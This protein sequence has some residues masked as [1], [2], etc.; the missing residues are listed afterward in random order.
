MDT[1]SSPRHRL[2]G[3]AFLLALGVGLVM[4]VPV[5]ADYLGPDRTVTTWEWRRLLCHYEAVY[6]PPGAGWY[7]CTLDLYNTPASSCPS[8]G[9]VVGY[10]TPSACSWP[11]AFCQTPGCNMSLSTSVEGCSEGQTGCTAVSQT[12][13]LPEATVSGWVSCGVPG[14]GGWCLADADLS[15]T[16]SEPLAGYSILTLEGTRNVIPGGGGETFACLGALFLGRH[17]PDG[18]DQRRAGYPPA[19]DLW[20]DLRRHRRQRLVPL[21][22]RLQRQRQRS[23]PRVRALELRALT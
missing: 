8:T 7:G 12:T 22:R 11:S 16:G 1:L 6:N 23:F 5:L 10:F 3:L 19:G 9:D 17:I 14:A 2:A 15:L 18:H 20:R 4:T 21:R 13:T